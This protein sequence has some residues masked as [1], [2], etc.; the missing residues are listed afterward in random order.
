VIAVCAR[1]IELA[2]EWMSRPRHDLAEQWLSP[3]EL[4]Q[5]EPSR[6][7]LDR[8]ITHGGVLLADMRALPW[9]ARVRRAWQL[10]FPPAAF[11][12]QSFPARSRMLL[13]WL[14]VYR[15][16]RGLARLFR[17]AGG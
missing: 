12:Q 4:A 7:Y 2:D 1:S 11:M 14:Y 3:R 16:A 17:R 5:D 6:V 15:G 13:P 8:D 9:R 10:T